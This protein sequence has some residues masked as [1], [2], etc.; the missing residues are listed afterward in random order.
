MSESNDQ[1]VKDQELE[2]A[3]KKGFSIC[4]QYKEK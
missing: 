1:K 2:E 3:L 4:K